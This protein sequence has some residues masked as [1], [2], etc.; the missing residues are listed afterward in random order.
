MS[1]AGR[2][3]KSTVADRPE[4]DIELVC[5]IQP[6]AVTPAGSSFAAALRGA[7]QRAGVR[8]TVA[9]PLLSMAVVTIVYVLHWHWWSP[10]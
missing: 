7:K 6:K 10:R 2:R 8:K 4:A 1:P 5:S 9:A 3:P